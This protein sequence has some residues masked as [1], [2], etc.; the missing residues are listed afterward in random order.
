MA[1][2]PFA[3]PKRVGEPVT[4]PNRTK[5]VQAVKATKAAYPFGGG[6]SPREEKAELK[7]SKSKYLAGEK[8]EGE[9]NPKFPKK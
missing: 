9:K 1:R 4:N 6:E 8:K 7:M 3:Q 5:P 2:P